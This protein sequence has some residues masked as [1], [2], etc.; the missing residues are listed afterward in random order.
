[1][2]IES[3]CYR[4]ENVNLLQ[5]GD[6]L[7]AKDREI[8]DLQ[9]R[10]DGALARVQEENRLLRVAVLNQCSDS[11]CWVVTPETAKA[12]PEREFLESCRRY[13]QQIA[14][15]RGEFRGGQT[16]AQ[17]EATLEYRSQT[18]VDLQRQLA[19][20]QTLVTTFR[21][22]SERLGFRIAIDH[23]KFVKMQRRAE[24]AEAL[25]ASAREDTAR[26]DKLD[27]W[28]AEYSFHVLHCHAGNESARAA[29]DAL[30]A[31]EEG[32]P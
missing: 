1:M 5:A 24:V 15:E 21:M 32:K 4:N 29:I 9:A 28:G 8:V 22:E 17:L 6:L 14:D 16:I 2:H 13:R 26:L 27:R 23:S 20:A 30:P 12:L 11:L 10:F 3:I 25:L 18:I 19:E 31:P 7:L